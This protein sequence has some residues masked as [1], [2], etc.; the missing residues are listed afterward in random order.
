MKNISENI[1]VLKKIQATA[2]EEA[3]RSAKKKTEKVDD[4][5]KL[6]SKDKHWKASHINPL[7]KGGAR[8]ISLPTRLTVDGLLVDTRYVISYELFAIGQCEVCYSLSG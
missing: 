1:D 7:Y 6:E 3:K 2:H 8:K 4:K 5:S